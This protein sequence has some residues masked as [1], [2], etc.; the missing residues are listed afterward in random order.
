MKHINSKTPK[1]KRSKRFEQTD[2]ATKVTGKVI[3]KKSNRTY[4][5][6]AEFYLILF[7]F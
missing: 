5:P 2:Y 7:N 1:S 6:T 4:G 3:G